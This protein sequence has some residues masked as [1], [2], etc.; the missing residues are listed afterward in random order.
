M[1]KGTTYRLLLG[2]AFALAA[3]GAQAAEPD[4]AAGKD[5]YEATCAACHG[6]AGISVAPTYPN[7]AGQKAPYLEEQLKAF[8]DGTRKNDIMQPM[9]K[10]L[11]D[12]DTANVAGYL[13]S[14]KP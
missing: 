7:L 10:L 13:A 2:T 14:L 3:A 9:A 12:A 11:S 8:R 4:L 5:K 6:A 1:L